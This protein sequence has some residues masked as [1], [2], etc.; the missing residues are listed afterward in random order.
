VLLAVT[1]GMYAVHHGPDGLRAIAERVH[2]HTA[3]IADGLAAR[4]VRRLNRHFFDPLTVEVTDAAGCVDRAREAGL[5]LRLVDEHHVG[6]TCSE[7]TTDAHAAAVVQ[8]VAPD[9]IP[10]GIPGGYE[11]GIPD[12]LR[13]TSSYLEHPVFHQH[14]SETAMLRYLR[15]VSDQDYALDRRMIPLGSCT[16]K[17]NATAELE[18][19]S[20]PGFAE[21]HPLAPLGDVAGYRVLIEQLEEWLAEITGYAAVSIRP[22]AGSQGEP[23]GL[24]A[25]RAY[26][27]DRGEAQ[28]D[29]CVIP[30]SAQGTN[31]VSAVHSGFRVVV[32]ASREDGRVDL[33]ELA[34]KCAV[35]GDQLAAVMVTYPRRRHCGRE[36]S[37][38][39][40]RGLPHRRSGHGRRGGEVTSGAPSPT[41]QKPLA[42]AYVPSYLAMAGTRISSPCAALSK[43]PTS[44]TCRSTPASPDRLQENHDEQPHEPPVHRRTRVDRNGRRHCPR[45]GHGV[46]R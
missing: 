11:G 9:G 31:A 21:M 10:G 8:A 18:P 40:P 30:S 34:A 44:S 19:I 46:R 26:H 17:L 14:R 45:R 27:R 3:A 15:A 29:V 23:A 2:A 4:S 5:L 43:T 41:L 22:N 25:I 39:C 42:L 33:D 12:Q 16:M 38:A 35:H 37:A 13:R 20:W 32:V 28:R 24:L 6:I 1:A 7:I 36:R